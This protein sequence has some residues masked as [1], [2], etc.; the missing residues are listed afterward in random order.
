MRLFI[1]IPLPTDVRR[2]VSAV[3]ESLVESGAQGRFVP[4]ENFHITLH[5]IGQ[6]DALSDAVE[7]VREAVR[8]I[9]PFVL[10]LSHYGGFGGARGKTAFLSVTGDLDE[11][12]RL[13]ETLESALW[14]RGFSK[15]RGRLSPHITLG[16]NVTGDAGFDPGTQRAA[17]TVP[18]VVLYESTRVGDEMRYT[19]VHTEP[20]VKQD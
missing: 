3:Q 6:S 4:R 11:L 7:A 18:S 10:R 20:I 8:D 12:N 14:E 5:F 1:A 2:A 15:N 17:F 13:Y 19:A 9:R 16:R